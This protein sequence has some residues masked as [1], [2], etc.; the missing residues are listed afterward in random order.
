[1]S[2]FKSCDELVEHFDNHTKYLIDSDTYDMIRFAWE[3]ASSAVRDEIKADLE[4]TQARV[5]ELE[6]ILIRQ[7]CEYV[8]GPD[9]FET[10]RDAAVSERAWRVSMKPLNEVVDLAREAMDIF[11]GPNMNERKLC[12]E[13]VRLDEFYTREAQRLRQ[14][15]DELEQHPDGDVRRKC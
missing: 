6:S 3:E 7:Q 12:A 13:L 8:K 15:A 5:A 4:Q 10:W 9:G 1:M 14:Q 11:T 2:D